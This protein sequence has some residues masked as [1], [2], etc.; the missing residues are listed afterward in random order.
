M[1]EKLNIA[2]FLD[3]FFPQINGVVTS[4]INT[5][6]E[7]AKRGHN[8][9]G[10]APRPDSFEEY[11]DDYFPFPVEF[12]KGF[13]AY[14]YPDFRFTYPFEGKV[15][16]N[17]KDFKPDLVHFHAP[18][19]LG[20][21]AIRIARKFKIPVVGTFHTFFAEPEYLSLIGMEDSK[22]LNS[23]GWWYSNQYFERCDAVVSPGN[24]TAGILKSNQLKNKIQVI[25]NGVEAGK[26]VGF[27]YDESKFPLKVKDHEE[28]LVYIGRLSKEK[29]LDVLLKAAKIVMDKKENARLLIIGDGPSFTDM[30][31]MA[32]N[33]GILDKMYFSGAVPNKDLLESG[34][35]RK[36]KMFVTASTSENQPMTILESIMFG[37][38]IIGVN[39]KGIPEMVEGNGFIVPAG[40]YEQM[41]EKIVLLLNDE[42]LH[43]QMSD[44]SMELLGRHDIRFTTDQMEA[45]Y[46][47][48]VENYNNKKK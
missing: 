9:Y 18:F 24:A 21:Q 5:V 23:A 14:F 8:V 43:K 12:H 45:L 10:I 3:N 35:L 39:A 22:F 27:N 26:Y 44:T 13:S 28:W 20:Y 36:M 30:Q 33:M 25:S 1:K 41:A 42:A 2:F 16:K 15:I 47:N 46:Y 17:M 34:I 29:G 19:T 6:V 11:P 31:N 32:D 48:V 37:L 38:P 40:D 7:I 4:S